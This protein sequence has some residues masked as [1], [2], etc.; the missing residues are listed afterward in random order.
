MSLWHCG[1]YERLKTGVHGTACAL[2]LLMA[3]YNAVAWLTRRE[4]HLAVNAV[5]YTAAIW[6]EVRQ[7]THH[8][9]RITRTRVGVGHAA[10]ER[11]R[12]A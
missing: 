5:V 6:W 11:A 9:T 7:T 8:W 3:G 12:V 4:R 2:G 1:E 10:H